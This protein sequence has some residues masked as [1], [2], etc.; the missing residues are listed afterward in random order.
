MLV[1][2]QLNRTLQLSEIPVRIVSLVPSQTELLVDLG[3]ENKIVGVT[4][5]CVHPKS[6]RKEKKIVGGTK[7]VH[8]DKIKTLRPDIIICNKEENTKEIVA[9]CEKIAPVWVSDILT[10][11]DS[12]DMISSLGAIFNVADKA[13]DLVAGINSEKDKFSNFVQHRPIQKVAYLIWKNPYMAASTNTFINSIL[14]VN[15]YENIISDADSRYPEVTVD[16]LKLVDLVLLSSEPYPF[17]R[18]DVIQLEELLQKQVRL[19]DG[20]Y[21]SWYGSRLRDAFMYFRTL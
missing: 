6:L 8:Y 7:D 12:L 1:K 11:E 5:F 19:V 9:A 3:L 18:E 15:R 2:D 10:I 20:E 16:L 17:K 4:K 21:F 13:S 14:Q